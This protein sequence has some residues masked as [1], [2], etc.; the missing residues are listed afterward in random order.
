MIEC[1]GSWIKKNLM[2]LNLFN[3]LALFT[4]IEI[5]NGDETAQNASDDDKEIF[6]YL[7]AL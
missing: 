1:S 5:R 4:E 6:T 3:T 2:K 7:K